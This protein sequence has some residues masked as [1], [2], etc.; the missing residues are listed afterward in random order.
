MATVKIKFRPSSV[1]KKEGTIYYQVIHCRVTRQ[2]TTAYK[3]FAEEWEFMMSDM[4]LPVSMDTARTIYLST[5]KVKVRNDLDRL[6]QIVSFFN[7]K[8]KPY[9]VDDIVLSY[10][11]PVNSNFLIPFMMDIIRNFK[12]LGKERTS[13]TYMTTLNSFIRFVGNKNIVFDEINSELM[14]SYEAFLKNEE[15]VKMNTVSFYMR[16]MRAVY[17]RAVEKGLTIQRNPFKRV[18]TGIS[19][20]VKRAIPLDT[21]RSIKRLDLVMYP[22]LDCVRDIFMFSFYTR[23]MAF[24]DMAFLTRDNLKN[25]ILSYRRQKTGQQLFIKWEP[26]MQSI[27]D[28]Y[29][30]PG[31]KYL[32]PIINMDGDERRQYKNASHLMNR[33]LKR[34]GN[35][36]GL[37]APLTMY[38]ARHSWASIAKSKNVPLSVISEGMGHDSEK[39][40]L[41]YL[42]SLD[43][44]AVDRANRLI[45]RSV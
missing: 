4:G 26:C 34:I 21:V 38:V 40:T 36:I 2:I 9:T 24:V 8:G 37:S 13:E 16:V 33:K 22:S 18:Y 6:S 42:A 27:L 23:G 20:T 3:I 15:K 14:I 5:L 44:T 11:N 45:L 25:G 1:S 39:T 30:N 19:K 12:M 28:K 41:I 32:L 43:T 35:M 7:C 10:M 31:R 17:N 29:Y